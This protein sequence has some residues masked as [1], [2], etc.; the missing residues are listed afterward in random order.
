M[1][2]ASEPATVQ[3]LNGTGPGFPPPQLN[4]VGIQSNGGPPDPSMSG[5]I[6]PVGT[7]KSVLPSPNFGGLRQVDTQTKA[8]G[9]IQPPPDIRAIV[10]KTAQF[11]A[12]NGTN[13]E[14][15]ILSN[16]K[17]N[18]KF[19]F[20]RPTDPYHPYYRY[21]VGEF[22]QD[23]EGTAGPVSQQQQAAQVTQL[24]Q[25]AATPAVVAAP[26]I[27]PT[28]PLQ[29][30]EDPLYMVRVSEGM[31][32]EQ[33]DVIKLTAQFVARNGKQFLAGL[34][35]REQNRDL[36]RFLKPT[37]SEFHFFTTLCDSYSRVLMPPKG[38]RER[39]DQDAADRQ[40]ILE[41]CL[42]R[43]EWDRVQER[44]AAAAAS[45]AEA[46]RLAM[47]SIDWHDFVVVETIDF[48]DDEDAQ[49]PEPMTQRDVILLNKAA[50]EQ[51]VAQADAA[52]AQQDGKDKEDNM[53]VE[54]DE[55]ERAMVAE[56]AAS[57]E[58]GA[59]PAAAAPEPSTPADPSRP[60]DDDDDDNMRIVRDYKRPDVRAKQQAAA[61]SGSVI[62]PITGELIPLAQMQE[63]M[64]I[65][66][67]D[68][69]WKEQRDTMLS[70]I[71][72]TTKASDD[73]I[74]R[75][76]LGLARHRPDVF[77]STQEEVGAL[78][79]RSMQEA[80][81]SG[82]DRPVV[83]DGATR[84]QDLTTQLKNIRDQQ[85]QALK[86]GQPPPMPRPILGPA[87]PVSVMPPPP[88][89][90]PGAPSSLPPP[91]R[92]PP[93]QPPP[94]G[95]VPPQP[96][97]GPPPPQPQRVPGQ[98][99]TH[100]VAMPPPPRPPQVQL[101]PPQMPPSPQQFMGAPPPM[102]PPVPMPP[103]VPGG[104][105]LPPSAPPPMPDEPEAKRQRTEFVLQAEDLFLQQ[106]PGLSKV[107]VLCP[108]LE[109]YEQLKG[110]LLEVDVGSLT[111]TVGKLKT[112][113]AGVLQLPANKQ[114]ITREGVGVMKDDDTLAHYNVSPDVQLVLGVRERGGRRK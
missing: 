94:A 100:Q 73:E 49:L 101:P 10:D 39:L 81:I 88:V 46:E 74:G 33:L 18:V 26:A 40:G 22:Q 103:P 52:E 57:R 63:H 87:P 91:V 7:A 43:L 55:E 92:L 31:S 86:P 102:R 72:E 97:P 111:D 61:A 78:V 15:K 14:T 34:A 60:A 13:F 16:E 8:I 105:P 84:G 56:G 104:V 77:G 54:M 66:L 114:K 95:G 51:E 112:R 96:R 93:Q 11:V 21:R 71:R 80:Q 9:L 64:R 79:Q 85:G 58:N 89:R 20:L 76:L 113:L 50:Q 62:S 38:T 27:A 12:K 28:K 107:R 32:M 23:G 1:V 69:K 109:G 5:A 17:D 44:E 68:P 19:N 47:Q 106:H 25:Q 75:N 30:P 70:K 83:W 2:Q 53:E 37:S 41:R 4:E 98:P 108:E 45:Q 99:M 65:S 24:Q 35:G 6:V 59:P 82:G 67:I 90:P 36:F 3:V 48:Y 110:Q 29:K 42:R